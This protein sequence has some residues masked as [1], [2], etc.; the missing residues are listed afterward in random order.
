[1]DGGIRG[2]RKRNK[3]RGRM[4]RR[5]GSQHG[6]REKRR[7]KRFSNNIKAVSHRWRTR[8]EAKLQLVG[9]G[10]KTTRQPGMV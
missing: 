9:M 6:W 8:L 5:E 7:T 2:R 10:R 1:M 3:R 4:V